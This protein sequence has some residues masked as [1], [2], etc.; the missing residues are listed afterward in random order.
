MTEARSVT[1]PRAAFPSPIDVGGL[2]PI[3]AAA[4]RAVEGGDRRQRSTAQGGGVV[5]TARLTGPQVVLLR[6]YLLRLPR[7]QTISVRRA[8]AEAIE[9]LTEVMP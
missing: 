9:R 7:A 6:S 4:L 2:D 8:R 1:L 3:L 5:S